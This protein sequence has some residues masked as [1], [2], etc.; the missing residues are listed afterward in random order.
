M[1]RIMSTGY[2]IG[3]LG[4]LLASC[5]TNRLA[6]TGGQS[7]IGSDSRPVEEQVAIGLEYQGLPLEGGLGG[8]GGI[9]YGRDDESIDIDGE[10]VDVASNVL[11]IY[12]GARYE[13]AL[14]RFRPFLAGGLSA[15]SAEMSGDSASASVSDDDSAIG[16]YLTGGALFQVSDL[17]YLGASVRKTIGHDIELFGLE[18]DIDATQILFTLAFGF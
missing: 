10:T 5:A 12:G 13:W 6:V 4:L 11:E 18:G 9:R 2:L 17:I 3:A 1:K 15:V 16:L 7:D 14:D 8:E